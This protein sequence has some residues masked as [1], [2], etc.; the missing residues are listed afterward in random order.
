MFQMMYIYVCM[1]GG[2]PVVES[3][4]IDHLA[5][6]H[7][8]DNE[9]AFDLFLLGR[10]NKKDKASV[11]HP[12]RRA[13]IEKNIGGK[14]HA[15]AFSNAAVGF[16]AALLLLFHHTFPICFTRR[17]IIHA[18]SKDGGL[19]A[20]IFKW[21]SLGKP[22]IIYD[23]RGEHFSEFV[24]RIRASGSTLKKTFLQLALKAHR[25]IEWFIIKSSSRILYVTDALRAITEEQYPLAVSRYAGTIPCLS[26]DGKFYFDPSLRNE[27][28]NALGFQNRDIILFY[29]GGFQWYQCIDEMLEL[30]CILREKDERFCFVFLTLSENHEQLKK[31][32]ETFAPV[33]T[34]RILQKPHSE[35]C[36]YLN[37]SDFG[38]LLRRPS[39]VNTCAAPTK[40]A[41]YLLTGLPVI[42]TEGIGDYS[43][44]A[45]NNNLGVVINN[46]NHLANAAE[47][48]L[49][50]LDE[51]LSTEGKTRI[52]EVGKSRLSRISRIADYVHLYRSFKWRR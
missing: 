42:M 26:D 47:T 10:G 30:F 38:L 20:A 33:R 9:F 17:L 24:E 25:I 43:I 28:R 19:V 16:F 39:L 8:S 23:I 29:A 45:R 32:L 2:S 12:Q 35:I 11:F 34:F 51:F 22:Q 49:S 37:A 3:Q 15:F 46:L 5:L 44:M 36:R 6:L 14:L 4:V 13:A 52:S 7:Q 31:R 41:E 1:D 48:I 18:R 21:L 50:H 40:F 27:I